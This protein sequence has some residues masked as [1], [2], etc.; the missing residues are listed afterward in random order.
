[1][2]TIAQQ[3]HEAAASAVVRDANLM[4]FFTEFEAAGWDANLM[5][6]FIE[7]EAMGRDANLMGFFMEFEAM[8]I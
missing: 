5:G 4:G 7:F 6:F 1:M 2:K 3:H 8:R